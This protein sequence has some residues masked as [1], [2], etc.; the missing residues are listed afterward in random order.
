MNKYEQMKRF[1][2]DLRLQV[3]MYDF[4][5]VYTETMAEEEYF[6]ATICF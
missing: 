4:M 5:Y 6:I 1:N 3:Y 2:Y